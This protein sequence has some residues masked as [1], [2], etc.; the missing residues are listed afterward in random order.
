[1]DL[2]RQAGMA[3]RTEVNTTARATDRARPA[4][5]LILDYSHGRDLDVDFTVA[6]ALLSPTETLK[7]PSYAMDKVISSKRTKYNG[8]M[9]DRVDLLVFALDSSG[10]FHHSSGPLIRRIA[11]RLAHAKAITKAEAERWIYQRVAVAVG[12]ETG[13]GMCRAV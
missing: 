7:D 11:G 13:R 10:G 3:V 12:R 6:T 9:A 2:A 5:L 8:R 4:D 1:M